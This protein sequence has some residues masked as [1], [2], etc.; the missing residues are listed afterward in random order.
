MAIDTHV[1]HARTRVESERQALAEKLTAVERFVERVE[2]LSTGGPSASNHAVGAG[3]TQ[4]LA[5]RAS[6]DGRQAVCRAFA[7]T[8]RPHSVDDVDDPEPL[9]ETVRTEL[10]D[11]IAAALAP[12]AGTSFTPALQQAIV[13]EAGARR[14][15][16]AV[17]IAAL[18]REDA[19]LADAAATVASITDWLVAADETP[20]SACGFETLRE[21]HERLAAHRERCDEL[22]AERQQFLDEATGR[23]ADLGVSHRTLTSYLYADFPVD[24]PVLATAVALDDACVDCQR[25]VRAHLVRRA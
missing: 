16:T 6:S 20:L 5:G 4:S 3:A 12:N 15:E 19:A 24:H 22:A 25:A 9:L 1:D 2:G 17:T 18:D 23:G 11:S 13:A 21:R 14:Q 7:E 8:I 10:T